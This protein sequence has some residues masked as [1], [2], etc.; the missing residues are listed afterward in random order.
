MGNKKTIHPKTVFQAPFKGGCL[1]PPTLREERH[2]IP[3]EDLILG[4][5]GANMTMD[6]VNSDRIVGVATGSS[7]VFPSARW[8]SGFWQLM[9]VSL[10]VAVIGCAGLK[11]PYEGALA[12]PENRFLLATIDGKSSLWQA[13]DIAIRYVASS[14]ADTLQISGTVERLNTIKNF[15]TINSLRV[16]IHFIT[17]DG[18]ILDSKQLWSAGVNADD[19]FVR[20]TFSKQYPLPPG[21]S[22]IGFSY[23]GVVSMGGGESGGQ[24]DWEVWQRP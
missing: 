20:W 5:K 19:T 8:T 15:P 4:Q 6:G 10:W 18:I 11:A 2:Y 13:K 23:W 7:I 21:A 9:L 14:A 22:A 24:D 1:M 16:A 3:A 17:K 12:R